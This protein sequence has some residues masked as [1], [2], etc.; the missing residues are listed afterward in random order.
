MRGRWPHGPE[1]LDKLEGSV[2]A[3]ERLK[4]ILDTMYGEARLQDVCD[5]L[6][7]GETRVRQLREV[8][9]QAALTAIEAKPAG[10]PSRVTTLESETIRVLQERVRELE[11]ALHLAQVREEAALVLSLVSRTSQEGSADDEEKKTPSPAV[12]IRKPR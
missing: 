9:L 6:D 12:R 8:G 2:E 11:H 5:Q 10:R 4:A 7:L 1:Y 3:K